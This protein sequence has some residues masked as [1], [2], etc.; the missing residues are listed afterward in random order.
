LNV[1]STPQFG[2][3]GYSGSNFAFGRGAE[4]TITPSAVPE[5]A[6]L[7]LLAI[8]LAGMGARRRRQRKAS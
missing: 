4:G 2:D 3:F 8:G 7:S 5:P 1:S 6:S